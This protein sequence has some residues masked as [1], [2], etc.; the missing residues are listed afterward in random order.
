MNFIGSDYQNHLWKVI[1]ESLNDTVNEKESY[2]APIIL[3]IKRNIQTESLKKAVNLLIQKHEILRTVLY[4]ETNGLL[5]QKILIDHEIEIEKINCVH[6]SDSDEMVFSTLKEEVRKAFRKEVNGPFIKCYCMDSEAGCS[7]VMLILHSL[8]CDTRSLALVKRDLV[9]FYLSFES[10]REPV[11]EEPPL[12]FADFSEWQSDLTPEV[13]ESDLI[14][15]KHKLRNGIKALPLPFDLRRADGTFFPETYRFELSRE[16]LQKIE[17]FCSQYKYEKSAACLAGFKLLFLLYTNERV[18]CFETELSGKLSGELSETIGPVSN[19]ALLMDELEP[20]VTFSEAVKQVEKT[21]REAEEHHFVPFYKMLSQIGVEYLFCEKEQSQIF[22]LWKKE[23]K[24]EE[25]S[26]FK[27]EELNLGQGKYDFSLLFKES[28][29]G[30]SLF[31]TYNLNV[32]SKN[33][34][35][36]LAKGWN[37]LMEWFVAN[38][39]CSLMETHFLDAEEEKH[40]LQEFNRSEVIYSRELTVADLLEQQAV[41]FPDKTAVVCENKRITYGELHDKSDQLAFELICRGVKIGDY[42]AI[43]TE[44]RVETIVGICAIVKAGGAYVPIDPDYPKQRIDYML[45]DCSPKVVLTCGPSSVVDGKSL[46]ISEILQKNDYVSLPKTKGSPE[47][48]IYLLY[49]SGTT[50]EP[51]GVMIEQKSVIRLVHKPNFIK[52][53]ENTVILQTGTLCFDAATL[54]IWGALLNGGELHLA[55]SEIFMDNRLLKKTIEDSG[56]N[57]MWLTVTLFNQLVSMDVTLF[58]PLKYLLIGGEKVSEFHIRTL[59]NHNARIALINGYGPTETTTFASTY[60][61]NPADLKDQTPIGKPI[62]NTQ[63]YI[64]RGMNLCAPLM[65]GELCIAGD[66]V[67]RGYLNSPDLTTQKF[68]ENPFGEGR[69]YR[70]GDLARWLPDGNLEYLGRSD[71]Q[72]KIRGF[73]IELGEIE[74]AVKMEKEITNAAVVVKEKEGEKYICVYFVSDKKIDIKKIREDLKKHLPEFM[75]PHYFAQIDRIP[76]TVNGKLDKKALPEI[77]VLNREAHG[78]PKTETEKNVAAVFEEILELRGIGLYDNFFEI[79]GHSLKATKLLHLLEERTGIRLSLKEFFQMP[80]PSGI[81]AKLQASDRLEA[82]IKRVE[83][84]EGYELSS[85]QKRIYAICSYDNTKT[86]YNINM[87]MESEQDLDYHAV[88]AFAKNLIERQESL[89]TSFVS[90]G[91]KVLQKIWADV[92]F[93]VELEELEYADEAEKRNQMA[94]FIRPFDLEKAPLFRMKLVKIKEGRDLLLFDMHHIISDGMSINLILGDFIRNMKGETLNPPEIQYKDY[95]EW[96]NQRDLSEQKT[97]WLEEL[98]GELP[99]LDL[100]NGHKRLEM[101]SFWGNCETGVIKREIKEA[102]EVFCKENGL[103][104]YMVLLSAY[105]ILLNR[106]SNQEDLIVG[107]PVSGRIYRQ[108]ENILGMF[109]NTLAMRGQPKDDKT[110]RQFLAEIKEKCLKAQEN[111]EYP[112]EELINELGIKRDSSGNPLFNVVFNFQ[113]IVDG[114]IGKQSGFE[115]IKPE[116]NISKFDLTVTVINEGE[117][118][119]VEFEYCTDLYDKDFIHCMM[120]HFREVLKAVI[121]HPEKVIS[122]LEICTPQEKVRILNEFNK[123]VPNVGTAS[124]ASLFEEQAKLTP[125]KIAVLSDDISFTYGELNEKANRLALKLQA[126]GVETEDFVAIIA[127]RRVETVA[128]MIAVVKAGA[129]Y[130]PIDPTYPMDRVVYML[131]DCKPKAVIS[132]GNFKTDGIAAV[133]ISSILEWEGEEEN[134]INESSVMNLAYL[135][136]T[137]GTTGRPKGTMIEQRSVIGLVKHGDYTKLNQ[138]TVILQTGSLSFDAATFEIWGSLLN[139]GRLCFTKDDVILDSAKLKESIEKNGVNT[140]FLTT[141]LFNQLINSDVSVFD[142]LDILLFGGESTSEVHVKKLLEYNNR[143]SLSNVYGPTETTTFAAWYPIKANQLRDKTPIGRPIANTQIYILKNHTLCGIGISGELCI[144]GNGV[145]RGYFRQKE[146]TDSKFIASPFGEGLLYRSG[147]LAR[148]LP[149]GNIEFLGR[150]DEQIK[151][152]GFRIELG[153]IEAVIRRQGNIL[154]TAVILREDEGERDLCAYVTADEEVDLKAFKS[155]LAKDLPSYMVPAYIMQLKNIP[156]NRNGKLD[157]RALPKIILKSE[158]SYEAPGNEKEERIITIFEE[159][160]GVEQVGMK[161]NFYELG[162]DSIKAIRIVARL[163]ELGYELA[164]RDIMQMRIMEQIVSKTVLISN[165]PDYEQGE[166]TGEG[167]LTPIQH[168]FFQ[169]NMDKP[170]HFNQSV[171]LETKKGFDKECLLETIAAIV[172]HHDILR[173][174]FPGNGISIRGMKASDLFTYE[175]FDCTGKAGKELKDYIEKTCTKIQGSMDISRG[176]L[177]KTALFSGSGCDYFMISIHHLVVDGISWRILLEDF[178]KGYEQSFSGKALRLPEK[179]ASYLKWS[180]ALEQFAKSDVLKKEVAYWWQVNKEIETCS[181]SIC[182][183][184]DGTKTGYGTA[185]FE[186]NEE[187]TGN[188]LYRA[189]KAYHTEINDILLTALGSGIKRWTGSEKIPI[190]LEGHGREEI[191]ED[192]DIT[193]TVGWFTSIFPILLETFDE[194]E[195]ALTRT[196]E[197]LRHVPNRGMGYEV[198]IHS[199]EYGLTEINTEVCFNYLGQW[200]EESDPKS[201][202]LISDMTCGLDIAESNHFNNS[203][204]VNGQVQ[205]DKLMIHVLYDRSKYKAETMEHFCG[206]YKTALLELVEFCI[207]RGESIKTASDY[208]SDITEDVLSE[209]LSL[210]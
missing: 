108:T 105:F 12:Q 23:E 3:K 91:D 124:I 125:D 200:K 64:L 160:L 89:K 145:G 207:S 43:L 81:A 170:N 208:N 24:W 66:G 93:Q 41:K 82:K 154:D 75:L 63:I 99:T 2:C 130:V 106:Y 165:S 191:Q 47:N 77:S 33:M 199:G 85:V 178:Y 94:S 21:C 30:L 27:T 96:M 79:G 95:S 22:Y 158:Q 32:Y 71:E 67:A 101:Q 192:I 152:R 201:S 61:I 114:S 143:I 68:V 118:Y 185:G 203:I 173:A 167:E 103:T 46:S 6:D 100:F 86:A 76:L 126:I 58:D 120:E 29:A 119:G 20:D 19:R 168:S 209:L 83:E 140:M 142:S 72:I 151:L 133:N 31:I 128:A 102:L 194:Q 54:E 139:G 25:T 129:A 150:I 183:D 78:E 144:A 197:M 132:Y 59:L 36:E 18:L 8:I 171:M 193:R 107:S 5:Y 48:I 188:L 74:Q 174:I 155:A 172:R 187:A 115:I 135:I 176:P 9:Q 88:T 17:G 110:V 157:K 180:G 39:K 98:E 186:L 148:W 147:D 62:S 111:Q 205:N 153:E 122:E 34:V 177:M 13:L 149:D 92:D 202:I 15:W 159:I 73:R 38:P 131:E 97:F 146:L 117:E 87:G 14:Y 210:F 11:M 162:G 175:I 156:V 45:K 57:T 42:V 163:R 196:K 65:V 141:A 16:L 184:A 4:R 50:G 104:E 189:G 56:I 169:W 134:P 55:N 60:A 90:H 7:Y 195:K 164:I 84:K 37:Q 52:F 53:D 198:L 127:E 136:Y 113:N 137:S 161:D 10:E 49:T 182:A 190:H 26:E 69:M 70:S 51:K 1:E 181:G 112:L 166:V 80:T 123:V 204:S 206:L 138:D 179:T 40:I 121:R 35:I 109:V 116:R 28:C 44:K